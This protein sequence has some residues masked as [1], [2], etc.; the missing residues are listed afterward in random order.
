MENLRYSDYTIEQL[1][2]EV[3]KLKEKSMKAEQQGNLSELAIQERKMYI[4]MSYMLNPKDYHAEDIHELIGDPG[5]SFKIN[6]INGVMAWG[7]R[8]NLLGEM[9]EKEDALPIS[10]LGDK[11]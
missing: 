6:Y 4:V 9:Y 10:I 8:I 3:G 1:R 2:D 7:H 11:I 5:H